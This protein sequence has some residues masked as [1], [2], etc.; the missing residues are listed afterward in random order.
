MLPTTRIHFVLVAVFFS[1]FVQPHTEAALP[2]ILVF[3]MDDMG[4]GDCSTYNPASKVSLPN[5]EGLAKHGMRF[6]HAHSPSAVC[7]PSRYSLMTGNYPWRGRLPNGTWHFHQRSQILPGQQALGQLLQAADYNTAF[8]GKVHLGGTILSKATGKPIPFKYDYLDIDFSQ[9]WQGGPA[10]LGFDFTYCLPQGIQ[11][12]PYLAFRNGLLAGNPAD[13]TF[14][15]AGKHGN[16]E[17]PTAGFGVNNWD[18][19]LTGERLLAESLTFLDQHFTANRADDCTTPFFLLHCTESC[20]VPHTP[21]IALA[22]EP[23]KNSSGDAHLDMLREAD[24]QLGR[25]LNRIEKAGQLANTLVLFT[26]DNGGIARGKPGNHRLGHNSNAGLKGSKATIW[27]GGHRVPLIAHWGDRN[28]TNSTIPP[29]TTS[30]ALVGLQDI[31]ATLADL[32]GQPVSET[33][34]LDSQSFLSTL[35]DTPDQQCRSTML[36]QANDGEGWGQRLAQ[37][38]YQDSWKLV[39]TKDGSPQHLFNLAMDS[40]E[41][42]DRI[43]S[44]DQQ[45]RVASMLAEHTRIMTSERSTVIPRRITAKP[46]SSP[47]QTPSKT[48]ITSAELFRPVQRYEI[49]VTPHKPETRCERVEQGWRIRGMSP[50]TLSCKPVGDKPWDLST[51]RLMGLDVCNQQQAVTTV[52]AKLNNT[53]PLGWGRHCVGQAIAVAK[54]PATVGFVFPVTEPAYDGPAVFNDQLGK[55]NGHRHHWRQ[56]F[57]SDVASLSLELISSTEIIDIIVNDPFTAWEVTAERERALHELPY[58]DR[59]G[60]VR[61]VDWP[62][63]IHS[64]EVLQRELAAELAGASETALKLGTSRYGGWKDGPHREATGRFRTEKLDGR[65]WLVDPEGYLF[66]S[67]GACIAGTEAFTPATAFRTRQRFFEWLPEQGHPHHWL[68]IVK[69]GGVAFANYPAMNAAAALGKNWQQISRNGIHDRMRGW[70]MNTLGAW[71]HKK[72]QQDRKTPYVLLASIWWQNGRKVPAPFREDYVPELCEAIRRHA[73]AKNDPYCLGIFI[74]NEFEWPDRFTPMVLELPDGD[75]TKQW[76]IEQLK[77]KHGTLTA[78]NAAWNTNATSWLAAVHKSSK[79]HEQAAAKDI[80]PLYLPYARAF[81]QKSKEAVEKILPGTLFLGCR[82]HRGPNVLGRAAVGHA[83]VFSVNVYDSQVRAW[84]VPEDAEIPVIASEFHFGA[85]DHGVPSPGLSAVWDQRQQGLAY[86]RYLAS[87]L[88][89][90][91]FVGVH[92]FEWND[93]SAAGRKDRENHAVGFVDVTGRGNHPFVDIVGRV[94]TNKEKVRSQATLSVEAT[95]SN[96]ISSAEKASPASAKARKPT[97]AHATVMN[98]TVR[99]NPPVAPNLVVIMADDLGYADVGFNGCTDIPTPNIDAIAREGVRFTSGYVA[100]PVCGPSRAAFITGRYGQRFGFERNPIYRTNDPGMGLPRSETT[101]ADALSAVGY[102]C[103]I[104]GKWHLGAHETLHPLAR[105]FHEF[106]GHLGGGH[107]YLPE[108]LTIQDS[109]AAKDE[110]ESYRTWILKNHTPVK[111]TQY[112]TDE[113]SDAAVDFIEAHADQPFFLFLAYNAPHLPLQATT[114]YLNRF[115][116]LSGKRK[117]YAA[118]VS[119]VDDGVRDVLSALRDQHVLDDTL[120]VFLSDNGGPFLKNASQNT[121]LKGGKSDVW[122]G[123]YRVPFAARF[124]RGFP[125]GTTYDKPVLSLD[126]FATI[127]ALANAPIAAD[128]PLDGVN[129]IPYLTGKNQTLPHKQVFIRKFD[130]QRY[131]IRT[132]NHKL[133][134]PFEG[135]KP[136]LYNL[137]SDV[138]ESKNI[139]TENQNMVKDLRNQLNTWE[140]ELIAPVFQ[141]LAHFQAEQK[142][143]KKASAK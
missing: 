33:A 37:A 107:Q 28:A 31:F 100:Y 30:P 93:Q 4:Y 19:S 130:Q 56:F 65:W 132:G 58:L 114:K 83:D 13:L 98:E 91:R 68:G 27:E 129:L 36:V 137:E 2:N 34:A 124:P 106:F 133:V 87:A 49:V 131:A 122:E 11:G 80:E 108:A 51:F 38:L 90:P 136:H 18:S 89:N 40:R 55:P 142:S 54:E 21:P 50:L 85:V 67:T 82:C 84:Q 61:A 3:L 20:H 5:I 104:V 125:A 69:R 74:G 141:G 35:L 10:D 6:T 60:Q 99:K 97:R 78:L 57:P 70:G 75:S 115:P 102:R 73:W 88:A 17:I 105:G 1:I 135:A 52:L 62:D 143:R 14:W 46:V 41:A 118:M 113:F 116:T 72:L 76:V 109:T 59:F 92:W 86:A 25:L 43:D 112:L 111:P 23:V 126:I 7:A 29:G 48:G 44:P 117:T 96:L 32:T 63:K 47:S 79:T 16:S 123:G 134:I 120:V 39:V 128:R 81:F 26:S 119:A 121:P 42:H 103:G 12:P 8:V 45:Q 77:R 24:I 138:S 139:A 9:R 15:Q 140:K 71:S 95:V 94:N 22:G 101:I 64:A 66:F 110:N 127:A 53:K